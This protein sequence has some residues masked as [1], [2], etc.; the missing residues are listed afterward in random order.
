MSFE[1]ATLE[2]NVAA[3]LANAGPPALC[4]FQDRLRL[5]LL[6]SHIY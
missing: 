2:N 1:S 3:T 4:V 6:Y 5:L